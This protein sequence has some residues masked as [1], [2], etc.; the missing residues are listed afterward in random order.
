MKGAR[1]RPNR[2]ADI[3]GEADNDCPNIIMIFHLGRLGE[4]TDTSHHTPMHNAGYSAPWW[5]AQE[6][7]S[8]PD[9]NWLQTLSKA[10]IQAEGHVLDR[11]N[12]RANSFIPNPTST[13]CTIKASLV[14]LNR[15]LVVVD[16]ILTDITH[17]LCKF[18]LLQGNLQERSPV[19]I[20][21]KYYI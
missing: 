2:T 6:I 17:I 10:T 4:W 18:N 16:N 11:R 9:G 14:Q 19:W 7:W 21:F 13:G 1:C 5:A 12:M 20:D 3:M 15:L 8:A